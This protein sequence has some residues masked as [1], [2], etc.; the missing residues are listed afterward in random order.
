MASKMYSLVYVSSAT[1]ALPPQALVALLQTA[2]VRSADAGVT[3]ML[4][5]KDGNFM[6]VL[7]GEEQSVKATYSKI[8]EDPRHKGL[9]VLLAGP[10]PGR[11][12][13]DWSMAFRDLRS[14]ELVGLAGFSDFLN[15]SLSAAEFA[16]AP[17]RARRLLQTFKSSM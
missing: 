4:L 6:Q 7:E 15:T 17:D 5:Y 9:M 12:F 16:N 14:P 1:E 2:R 3:G 13:P 11:A 10:A 8:S